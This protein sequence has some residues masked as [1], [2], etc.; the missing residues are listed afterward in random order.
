LRA[1]HLHALDLPGGPL[2]YVWALMRGQLGVD[3]AGLDYR[4]ADPLRLQLLA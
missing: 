3:G 2:A 1:E 4:H